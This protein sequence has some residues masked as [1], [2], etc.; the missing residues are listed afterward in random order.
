MLR[1]DDSFLM[2]PL[3]VVRFI[4]SRKGDT[5]RGPAVWMHS[6]EAQRRIITDGELAWVYGPRRHEL[7]EVHVDDDVPPEHVVVR[8][9]VGVGASESVRVVKPDLDT[10]R[11]GSRSFA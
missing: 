11:G 7:A 1:G 4:A 8:D 6:S 9:I 10:T 3:R 2:R 5:E